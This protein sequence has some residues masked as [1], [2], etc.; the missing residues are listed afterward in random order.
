MP[1]NCCGDIAQA[2]PI[3]LNGENNK[4][5]TTTGAAIML[6]HFCAFSAS[7]PRL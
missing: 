2:R 1:G 7:L 3:L 4:R 6:E 5:K